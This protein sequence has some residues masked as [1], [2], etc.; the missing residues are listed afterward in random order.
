MNFYVIAEKRSGE[1]SRLIECLPSQIELQLQ[2]GEIAIETPNV[3]RQPISNLSF[4]VANGVINEYTPQ[5]IIDKQSRPQSR[6]HWSNITY[7][8]IH[9]VTLD[10]I[11]VSKWDDIKVV[12][13]IVEFGTFTWGIFEFDAT[14]ISQQRIM[15]AALAAATAKSIDAVFSKKWT[16]K[17]NSII[18]LNA[19]DMISVSLALDNHVNAVHTKSQLLR[20]KI[21]SATSIEE[22][23]NIYW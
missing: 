3:A 13:D 8:W 4:Y 17:D 5:Q 23:Q 15:Q 14:Q 21:E 2:P 11:K 7:R 6:A 9:E 18:T 20:S 1:I 12:R 10:E 16:L 22:V 19:D